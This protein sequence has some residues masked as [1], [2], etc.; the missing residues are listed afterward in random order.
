MHPAAQESR[1]KV[2]KLRL[3][4]CRCA[5]SRLKGKER[6]LKEWRIMTELLKYCELHVG[7]LAFLFRKCYNE[8]DICYK[9]RRDIRA[10]YSEIL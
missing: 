5:K 8:N 3:R 10:E 9:Q 2:M 4:P 1:K 6:F 7:I